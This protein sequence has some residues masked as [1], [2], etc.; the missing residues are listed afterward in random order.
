MSPVSATMS[1]F[2]ATLSL[3]WTGLKQSRVQSHV[4]TKCLHSYILLQN[5]VGHNSGVDKSTTGFLWTPAS[6]FTEDV[7]FVWVSLRIVANI[8]P[9]ASLSFCVSYESSTQLRIVLQ[10]WYLSI[11]VLSFNSIVLSAVYLHVLCLF[12]FSSEWWRINF[13]HIIHHQLVN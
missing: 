7:E 9:T 5:A 1:P 4:T 10:S 8:R 11:S 6:D 3:V 13:I 2:L 12:S